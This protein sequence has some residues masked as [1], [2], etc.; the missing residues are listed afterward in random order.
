MRKEFVSCSRFLLISGDLYCN[1]C[2]PYS[3]SPVRQTDTCKTH[4]RIRNMFQYHICY[5]YSINTMIMTKNYNK[6]DKKQN[7][8]N[9]QEPHSSYK[10][11]IFPNSVSQVTH[12][13]TTTTTTTTRGIARELSTKKA[14]IFVLFS[15]YLFNFFFS[16]IL[17]FL[18]QWSEKKR[19][20]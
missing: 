17:H 16:F 11:I 13:T 6:E 20:A 2:I 7:I 4:V 9:R 1:T 15:V 8:S 10:Q 18:P 12:T 14:P 5:F 19:T 3:L